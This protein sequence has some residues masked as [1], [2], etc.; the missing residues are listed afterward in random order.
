M[1]YDGRKDGFDSY[2]AAIAAQ[3]AAL[4]K[5]RCPAAKRVE[6]IDQ[7]ELYLGDSSE[8]ISALGMVGA[9]VTDPPYGIGAGRMSLG[10]WRTSKMTKGDWD[11]YAPDLT[12]IIDLGVP[13]IV[14][15]GN[16]FDLR[17]SRGYLVW[18]KG[19]GFRGRDFAECEF[20][21]TSI[22]MNARVLSHDPL[23]R[24]DYKDKVHP[25]QKPVPLM[26]WCLSFVEAKGPVLDPFMGSG[27]TGVAC[28]K[29]GRPFIG[30]E[31][32][33]EYFEAACQRIRDAYRQTDLFAAPAPKPEPSEQFGLLLDSDSTNTTGG[34]HG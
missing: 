34:D 14:W 3:R 23:A 26:R 31:I 24:G 16:Y 4:L 11:A 20:A 5:E 32:N 17:P 25:T 6:V 13:T 12:N 30:I 27:S 1:N 18:D 7:C 19:A 15:G 29:V 9:V 28:A 2:N 22:D 21:W 33:E 8:I 10:K